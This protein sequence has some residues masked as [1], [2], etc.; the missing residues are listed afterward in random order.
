MDKTVRE[1]VLEEWSKW[2]EIP[3]EEFDC[4][5]T[6]NYTIVFDQDTKKLRYFK[7]K[8]IE[9]IILKGK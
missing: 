4:E 5:D 9:K 3:E 6:D 1:I 7:K 8:E 2:A